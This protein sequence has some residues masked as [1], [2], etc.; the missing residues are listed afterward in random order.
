MIL[1]PKY[2]PRKCCR[3]H[4]RRSCLTIG[5]DLVTTIESIMQPAGLF[6]GEPNVGREDEQRA[7]TYPC[8]ASE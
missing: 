2:M 5:T 4:R 3:L 6:H 1:I 8:L 7:A